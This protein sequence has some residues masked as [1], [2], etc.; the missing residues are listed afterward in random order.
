[1]DATKYAKKKIDRSTTFLLRGLLLQCREVLSIMTA[2]VNTVYYNTPKLAERAGSPNK[3]LTEGPGQLWALPDHLGISLS[4]LDPDMVGNGPGN[5]C[6][7]PIIAGYEAT[8]EA[9]LQT[10][11]SSECI[12]GTKSRSGD[13][14]T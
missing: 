13:D 7:L 2:S 1:M 14:S 6:L 3:I 8:V 11:S 10:I 12:C 4:D 9:F 5:N